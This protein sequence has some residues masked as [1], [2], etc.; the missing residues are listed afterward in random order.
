MSSQLRAEDASWPTS[1]E[2]PVNKD[3][4]YVCF[5]GLFGFAYNRSQDVCEIGTNAMDHDHEFGIF[6]VDSDR[7]NFY[8]I[9][10]G[11]TPD[12]PT[13]VDTP[14]VVKVE[15][16]TKTGVR[17]YES[18][19]NEKEKEMSWS[20]LPDIEGDPWYHT[21]LQKRKKALKPRLY[22][23]QGLFFTALTTS[24]FR[25]NCVI[26]DDKPTG[27]TPHKPLGS[28]ALL[29][30]AE[31]SPGRDGA[32]SLTFEDHNIRLTP[33]AG[34]TYVIFFSNSCPTCDWKYD[35]PIK[36][37]RNDFYCNYKIFKKPGDTQYGIKVWDERALPRDE[38]TA[39]FTRVLNLVVPGSVD[40]SSRASPCGGVGF[41]L[42]S[43]FD[44]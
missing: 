26:E 30:A 34:K 11:F 13:D 10:Y 4:I 44:E 14:V 42:S 17:F 21:K 41:G 39:F 15:N 2:P 36:E 43:G 32:V 19:K 8:N 12:S 1:T 16:P 31:L 6:V 35:S 22:V 9:L 37:K 18:V 40:R 3:G 27:P 28:I 33:T 20:R 23:T 5:H 38:S 25:F 29:S 7:M 24:P